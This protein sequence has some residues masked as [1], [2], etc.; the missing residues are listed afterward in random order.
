MV[1][2]QLQSNQMISNQLHQPHQI[3]LQHQTNQ[4][5]LQRN[6]VSPFTLH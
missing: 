2:P 1:H 3:H 5:Q 4:Q 6:Q